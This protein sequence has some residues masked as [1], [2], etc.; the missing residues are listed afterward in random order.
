MSVKANKSVIE[1]EDKVRRV[2][3][4]E[5]KEFQV[6]AVK[7][8]RKDKEEKER[9]QHQQQRWF[10]LAVIGS[11]LYTIEQF[12]LVISYIFCT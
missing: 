9:I 8:A 6:G 5:K 2:T 3:L 11:R 12:I 1:E 10:M 7:N 4:I